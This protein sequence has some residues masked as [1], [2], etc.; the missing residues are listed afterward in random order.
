MS[1][2]SI[3]LYT[4]LGYVLFEYQHE[5]GYYPDTNA[6]CHLTETEFIKARTLGEVQVLIT[7]HQY[8]EARERLRK[9]LDAV[10]NDIELHSRYH[11]LLMLLD[12]N[13]ALANH[14]EHLVGLLMSQQQT[15]RAVGVVLDAQSKLPTFALNKTGSAITLAQRMREQGHYRNLVRLFY[16]LH[17]R[18]PNDPF[19]PAAYCLVAK[20]FIENLND[21][22]NG[23][24]IARYTLKKHPNCK[25][26]A[27]LA[28]LI[29]L[30]AS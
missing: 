3:A 18:T 22:K 23:L 28:T 13:T 29:K 9:A 4:M 10:R 17:K 19:L 2:F 26:Q 16:N 24:A 20:T 8:T 30:A 7:D 21:N 14:T 12:D 15:A 1:Y 5:L 6:Q 27:E 11:K 25:E